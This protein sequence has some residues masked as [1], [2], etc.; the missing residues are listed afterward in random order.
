MATSPIVIL[1]LAASVP[2]QGPAKP[3]GSTTFTLRDGDFQIDFP[4]RPLQ[5]SRLIPSREG[6]IEQRVYVV[7]SGGRL[8]SVRRLRYPR[9]IPILQVTDRLAEQKQGLLQGQVELVRENKVT[10]DD[11]TGDHLEYKSPSPRANGTIT[12]LTRQFIKGSSY[13]AI[14]VQSA[15]GQELPREA[16]QFLDSFHFTKANPAKAGARPKTGTMTKAP[17]TAKAG[18]MAKGQRRATAGATPITVRDTTPEDALCTFMVAAV[19]KDEAALRAVTLPNPDLGWLLRGERASAETV[20][21]VRSVYS[22]VKIRRLKPGEQV[23]LPGNSTH[24]VHSREVT[25]D[26]ALLLPEGARG[27]VRLQR[28]DGHW[29]IDARA[30]IAASKAAATLRSKVRRP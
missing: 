29:K 28:I 19:A 14:T 9:T 23:D 30:A 18:T 4:A 2:Y 16:D 10:L 17:A 8:F 27:P 26:R 13:Y 20:E 22:K 1:F 15:P 12:S 25:E 3:A 6:T 11:V 21:Q 7:N 24:V 5:R